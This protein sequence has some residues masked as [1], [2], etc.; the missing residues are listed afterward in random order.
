MFKQSWGRRFLVKA[1]Q[2]YAWIE[3]RYEGR[4]INIL[5]IQG[6]QYTAYRILCLQ[7]TEKNQLKSDKV[8]AN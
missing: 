4:E 6:Q 5:I 1:L 3:T 2:C 7:K 8:Q